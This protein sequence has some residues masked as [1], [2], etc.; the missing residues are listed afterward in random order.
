MSPA[1]AR[2]TLFLIAGPNGAGKTTFFETVLKSRVDALFINADAIQREELKDASM[3]ASYRAARLADERRTRHLQDRTS[4]VTE[5]VFSH[6]SKLVLLNQAR[7]AGF[8]IVVFH[9]DVASADLSVARVRARV[10]EGGHPVP[11]GKIRERYARNKTLIRKA[12]LMA[13]AALVFEGSA[14]NAP[15]RRLARFSQ[16]GVDYLAET[17]PDWFEDLY[18]D[19]LANFQ[20]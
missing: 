5:T 12:V 11:E 9:I 4:F 3:E 8:R 14:L 6:E 15:P 7:Q 16:G 19:D 13:D 17:R 10:E 20:D 2:P 1:R 18:G